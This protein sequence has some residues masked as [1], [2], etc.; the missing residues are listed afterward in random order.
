MVTLGYITRE[1]EIKLLERRIRI[2]YG[3]TRLRV[4]IGIEA[5]IGVIVSF[6]FPLPG[7]NL[8][9]IEGEYEVRGGQIGETVTVY[10]RL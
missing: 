10:F 9:A 5:G 6:R 3:G 1:E 4:R 7:G 8:L 2:A